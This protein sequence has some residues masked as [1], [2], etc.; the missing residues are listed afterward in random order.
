MTTNIGP[1]LFCHSFNI[2]F[3]SWI[4]LRYRWP[5]NVGPIFFSTGWALPK[6]SFYSI[7]WL[8]PIV[9]HLDEKLHSF[10]LYFRFHHSTMQAKSW[11]RN[12]W[13]RQVHKHDGSLSFWL[14]F[15]YFQKLPNLFEWPLSSMESKRACWEAEG[16]TT[17]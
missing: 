1:F 16:P 3:H 7:V 17:F 11:C 14:D 13:S 15:Y 9:L 6:K 5:W 10:I 8:L 12:L 2:L 4:L